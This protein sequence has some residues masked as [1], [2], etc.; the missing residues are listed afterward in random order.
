VK[1]NEVFVGA[2]PSGPAYLVGTFEG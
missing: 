2:A 1:G